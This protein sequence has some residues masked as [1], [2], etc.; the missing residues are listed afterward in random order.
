MRNLFL[1]LLLANALFAGWRLWVAPPEVP[2]RQLPGAAGDG[3]APV[4]AL[5]R[6]EA[7]ASTV[8]VAGG[9][10][11]QRQLDGSACIRIGPF[12]DGQLADRLRVRLGATGLDAGVE[13]EEG[14]VRVG[15]EVQIEGLAARADAERM[16]VQLAAAGVVDARVAEGP[17]PFRVSLGVFADREQAGQVLAAAEALGFQPRLSDRYRPAIRYWVVVAG[18]SDGKLPDLAGF[19]GE[20]G[21][22]LQAEPVACPAAP[23]GGRVAIH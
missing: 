20:T 6:S 3:V 2:A 7:R 19:E 5:H 4:L 10:A 17:P 11:S 12:V 15:H 9:R 21:Q 23:V 14:R 22:L 16:A 8:P 1:A 13:R 18:L